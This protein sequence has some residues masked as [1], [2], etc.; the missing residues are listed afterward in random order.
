[1]TADECSEWLQWVKLSSIPL[2]Q[3][4]PD[5][6]PIDMAS[7]CFA[8]YQGRKFILTV[9]HA[10]KLNS[11]GWVIELRCDNHRGTEFYRVARFNY[12]S[13]INRETGQIVESDFTF[14]EVPADLESI[15]WLLTPFGVMSA[16]NLAMYSTWKPFESLI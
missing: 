16:N 15:F 6:V 14:A 8:T 4:G 12:L 9:S 11:S 3:L 5:D 2:K 1:M 7:G 13:G 10:V